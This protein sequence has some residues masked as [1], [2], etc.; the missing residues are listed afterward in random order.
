MGFPGMNFLD[1]LA[2]LKPFIQKKEKGEL[3]LEDIL[4]EDSIIQDIK[5][6]ND[7]QFI[8]FLT[9]EKIKKLIDYSTKFPA[10]DEHNIG[11]KYPFNATEILCS[12]NSNLQKVLMEE[13]PY[14]KKEN[15]KEKVKKIKKGGFLAQL[16]KTINTV[17]NE[18]RKENGELI[19]ENETNDIEENE[20]IS[21]DSENEEIEEKDTTDEKNKKVIYENIDYLLQFLNESDETNQN[22]VL[23][24]YF[25]KILNSLINTQQ[26]KIIQYILD[27]P[28]KEE[29]DVLGLLIKHMNR[30]S[31]CNIIQKI[32]MFDDE[33]ITKFEEKKLD[34][35]SK[36]F[37]E[38]NIT[39]EKYKYECIC[40][41]I[42][43][44][45]NN[46]QFF[47][48]FMA[49]KDL[50]EKL[51]NILFNSKENN[52]KYNSILKLLIKIN[53][54][55]LQHFSVN[56]TATNNDNNN[57]MM[58][59][60]TCFSADKSLSSPE[61]NTD[62]LKKFLFSLFDILEN[63]KF[64]FFNDLG[65][66]NDSNN[67]NEFLS[68]YLEKQKKIGIKKI[69]QTEYLKTIIDIFVNSNGSKYHEKKIEQLVKLANE[70]NIFWNLHDLF[71]NFPNS[72]IFQIH[73]SQIMNII[74]NENS[75]NCLIDAF[76]IES[77]NKKRNLIDI[78]IDNII[79]NMK[80]TFK[81][82]NT[83]SLNPC[84]SYSITILNKIYNSKNSYIKSL[85]EKNKNLS[86]FYETIG[87]DVE[88]T[89]NQKLLLNDPIGTFGDIEEAPLQTFGPK[90]FLEVFEENCKIYELYK[91]GENY[92]KVLQEKKERIEKEK[93]KEKEENEK[94][95]KRD[96]RFIDDYE[97]EDDDP[98]FKVE[99]INLNDNKNNLL[100]LLNRPPKKSKEEDNNKKTI[101]ADNDDDEEDKDNFLSI[102][103]KPH[104]E[105]KKEENSNEIIQNNDN[106]NKNEGEKDLFKELYGDIQ[107]GK[108]ENEIN[109]EEKEKLNEVKSNNLVE[110]KENNQNEKK[111]NNNLNDNRENIENSKE[112]ET[113]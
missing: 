78:Y 67:N 107:D 24:G 60:D 87:Q 91:K 21:N 53:E 77:S 96:L 55:I 49:K 89:F 36:I 56:Y 16:F 63:N 73:Y 97:E 90:S 79:S 12:E 112:T 95:K 4:N 72:N 51:Y 43:C 86:V 65:N 7:S 100:S 44:V 33:L 88:N 35:L 30:K 85:N 104:Q 14:I 28:R 81:L 20:D 80:F 83:E 3:T 5:S 13:K 47:D 75:P 109:S 92:Q 6:N 94:K 103:N 32:L 41:C 29:F 18:I 19:E 39:D 106:N 31:M 110:V 71:F 10:E 76:L 11:Y 113:N 69:I 57:E 48:L 93:E 2:A 54:N 98:L 84:F 50:L 37:D 26:M 27:Y 62:I 61:D 42:C 70:Q 68:T 105:V 1:D 9:S 101:D 52:N 102:L 34:L 15:I 8:D 66:F 25:Y 23:V 46:R 38:L 59:M 108:E 111:E 64:I 99:K 22:Y 17:K 58:P 45:M 74:L 82:T 40:D